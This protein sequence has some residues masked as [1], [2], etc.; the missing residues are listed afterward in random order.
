M[1]RKELYGQIQAKKSMLCVGLD[2][3]FN[4]MPEHIKALSNK[5]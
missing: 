4:K 5:G 1:D 3:D 2:V